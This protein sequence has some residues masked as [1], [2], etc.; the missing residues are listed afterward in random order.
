LSGD[1]DGRD[2]PPEGAEREFQLFYPDPLLHI[3]HSSLLKNV[4]LAPIWS[5]TLSQKPT[6]GLFTGAPSASKKVISRRQQL[7]IGPL[8]SSQ[9]AVDYPLF[10]HFHLEP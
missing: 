6:S 3:H 2:D 5:F 1:G 9:L 7:V 10:R 4:T 8:H